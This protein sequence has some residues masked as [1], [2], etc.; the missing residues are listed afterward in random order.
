MKALKKITACAA[1]L[2]LI[3]ASFSAIA[4][5]DVPEDYPYGEAIAFL[6]DSGVVKG[7]RKTEILHR[8]SF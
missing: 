2:S 7:D 3:T 5:N 8:R 4:Y 6:T 1:A